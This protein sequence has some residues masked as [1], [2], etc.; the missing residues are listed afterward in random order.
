VR[1][2]DTKKISEMCKMSGKKTKPRKTPDQRSI[3]VE[4]LMNDLIGFGFPLEHEG[5]QE[6]IKVARLFEEQGVSA[7][8]CIK[9]TGFQ[10]NMIYIF[11]N[12]PKIDSR[13][14]LEHNPHV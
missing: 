2:G 7:S 1:Y 9:M 6:L 3:E 13:I 4:K 12:Q 8:G 11:S 5:I 14:L 10:R